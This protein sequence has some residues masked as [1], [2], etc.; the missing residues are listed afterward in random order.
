MR[1]IVEYRLAIGDDDEKELNRIVNELIA[2]GFQPM[3]GVS[4]TTTREA[5]VYFV[6]A[7]VRYEEGND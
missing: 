4:A 1:R 2:Q 6:Q 3:G 7:M 5:Y